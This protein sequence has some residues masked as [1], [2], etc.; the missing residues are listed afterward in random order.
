MHRS[1]TQQLSCVRALASDRARCLSLD[2]RQAQAAQA[3]KVAVVAVCA[4]VVSNVIS[5]LRKYSMRINEITQPNTKSQQ[6]MTP[7]QARIRALVL[8]VQR[9]RQQLSSER[10]RQ[11]QQRAL[12]QARNI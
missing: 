10:E 12:Q 5:T 8:A 6:S 7:E 4:E 1:T 9:S 2:K 11:R 3:L